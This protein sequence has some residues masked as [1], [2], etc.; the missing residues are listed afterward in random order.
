[1]ERAL[2]CALALALAA[3]PFPGCTEERAPHGPARGA[4]ASDGPL[5]VYA[6]NQPLAYF[7]GRI[8]G[9]DVDVRFPAP[10]DVDPAFWSPDAETVAAFQRADLIL[11]NGAGYAAWVRLATLPRARTVDTSSGFAERLLPLEKSVTHGH[12]PAGPHSHAGTASTTW[13]DPNL[14]L[15]QARA[16]NEAL[17][18]A[19][20]S[21]ATAFRDRFDALAANLLA[22]DARLAAWAEAWGDAPLLFSH[23]VYQYL[24]A[25][26]RLDGHSLHWEPDAP[27]PERAWRQL[28]QRLT[29]HPARLMLWEAEPLGET[30]QRL[31]SLGVRPVVFAPCANQAAA[32]DFLDAMRANVERLEQEAPGRS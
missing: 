10:A 13:L 30:R 4:P 18:A 12:G 6:V 9:P 28:E 16:V 31:D 7:A 20:P 23:P 15:E 25:R 26:Y 29:E 19:L 32:G 11:L 14:A 27:P 24:E 21:R 2:L 22:L 8:G 17:A 3:A 5:V 1:M